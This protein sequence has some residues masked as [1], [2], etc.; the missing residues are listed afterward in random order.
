MTATAK[1]EI[2][3]VDPKECDYAFEWWDWAKDR[4]NFKRDYK[5]VYTGEMEYQQSDG[6]NDILEEL[7]L[8]FNMNHPADYK[9][10][11]LSVSDIIKLNL[12]TDQI[13]IEPQFFY[14]DANGWRMLNL[15]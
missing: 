8:K 9:G 3:Q 1:F 13:K 5:L 12:S 14:C 10:H 4:L 2:Y 6:V 7:F 15:E 11:S